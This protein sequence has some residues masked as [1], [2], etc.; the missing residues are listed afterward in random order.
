MPDVAVS[1]GT[2]SV[3]IPE[4]LAEG[5]LTRDTEMPAPAPPLA[6]V[7]AFEEPPVEVPLVA[8]TPEFV[9]PLEVDVEELVPE[10]LVMAPEEV[11]PVLEFEAA[12]L[13]EKIPP[14]EL[15]CSPPAALGLNGAPLDDPLLDEGTSPEELG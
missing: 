7:S 2:E 12:P 9:A 4:S 15:D 5:A 1:L 8:L 13:D 11:E 3:T 6:P 14:D 10:L